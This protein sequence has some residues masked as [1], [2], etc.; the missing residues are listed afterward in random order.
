M[1]NLSQ[2]KKSSFKLQTSRDWF[3]PD[4]VCQLH[5]G[6]ILVVEY[7][8]EHLVDSASEKAAVGAIWASRSQGKCLFVMPSAE[9]WDAIKAAVGN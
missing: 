5:D 7:K 2:K 9:N 4:F 6:R 8:G 1:R 3:Y